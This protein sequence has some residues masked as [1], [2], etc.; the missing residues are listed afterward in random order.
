MK[1]PFPNLKHRSNESKKGVEPS[2]NNLLNSSDTSIV[3]SNPLEHF[4]LNNIA[5]NSLLNPARNNQLAAE[6]SL[7]SLKSWCGPARAIGGTTRHHRCR[8]NHRHPLEEDPQDQDHPDALENLE[9][10]E[11]LDGGRDGDKSGEPHEDA[12]AKELEETVLHV[13]QGSRE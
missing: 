5:S 8:Q 4:L 10:P 13:A 7:K 11:A 12:E 1:V 9:D 6:E 3:N 2:H